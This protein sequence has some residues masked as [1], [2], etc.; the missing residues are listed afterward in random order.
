[1]RQFLTQIAFLSVLSSA[2]ASASVPA[3]LHGIWQL[4]ALT[5]HGAAAPLPETTLT[6]SGR[7]VTGRLGCGMFRGS[8]SADDHAVR[9]SVTP[10][11]PAPTVRCLHAV[12]GTFHATLNGVTSYVISG[13]TRQ[14]VLV[15]KTGRLTFTRIGYV[16]PASK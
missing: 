3:P 8:I 13:T 5:S 14:L 12:P 11:P 2:S 16:T 7:S 4:D 1:M 6:I 15:S 10:L 9:V